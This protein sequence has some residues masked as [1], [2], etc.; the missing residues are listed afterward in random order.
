MSTPFE[1]LFQQFMPINASPQQYEP[2]A[3]LSKKDAE[4]WDKLQYDIE[5]A[6]S[7]VKEVEAKRILFWAKIEKKLKM[8]DRSLMIEGG[9]IMAVVEEKTNCTRKKDEPHPDFCNGDC[10]NCT[11]DHDNEPEDETEENNE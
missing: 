8:Y 10:E 4:A 2:I 7:L 3:P 6:K 5:K 11:L 1:G 9:M